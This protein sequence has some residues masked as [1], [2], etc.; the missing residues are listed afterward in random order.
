[1]PGTYYI[2]QQA[3]AT[4]SRVSLQADFTPPQVLV[5]GQAVSL[6]SLNPGGQ[7]AIYRLDVPVGSSKVV[8]R[9]SGGTGN[10][11]LYV[12]Q[13]HAP[14]QASYLCRPA[15]SGNNETCTFQPPASGAYYIQ[16]DS[17]TP[18]SGVNLKG[19]TWP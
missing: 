6:P 15:A 10:A 18:S 2:T 3:R 4:F 16:V 12:Q 13:G 14:T 17:M 8:I 1:M 5:S 9:M 7:T 19:T 11:D